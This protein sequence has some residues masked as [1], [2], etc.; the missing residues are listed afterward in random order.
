MTRTRAAVTCHECKVHWYA[1]MPGR[2]NH[3]GPLRRGLLILA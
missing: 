3:S 1:E 2:C